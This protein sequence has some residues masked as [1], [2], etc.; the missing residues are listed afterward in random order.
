MAWSDLELGKKLIITI[1]VFFKGLMFIPDDLTVGS[2]GNY[3][4]VYTVG[5]K[6]MGY[7]FLARYSIKSFR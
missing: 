6:D 5:L 2:L 4:N 7:F 3:Y 1:K